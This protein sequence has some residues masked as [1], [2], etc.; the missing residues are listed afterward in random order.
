MLHTCTMPLDQSTLDSDTPRTLDGRSYPDHLRA[1]H[2]Y[3]RQLQSLM[4]QLEPATASQLSH[5]I[6][7]RRL[8]SV[9]GALDGPRR[10]GGD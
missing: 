6:K 8:R 9:L 3:D 1:Y 2:R 7:N 5:A 10:S 4:H